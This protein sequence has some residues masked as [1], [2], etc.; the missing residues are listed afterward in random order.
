MKGKSKICNVLVYWKED[1]G[2]KQKKLWNVNSKTKPYADVFPML[3]NQRRRQSSLKCS[4]SD[5]YR[6]F[7]AVKW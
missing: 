1:E 2:I 6:Y 4:T 3:K 5:E 7:T